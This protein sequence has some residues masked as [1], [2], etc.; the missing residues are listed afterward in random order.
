ME[1]LMRVEGLRK[2]FGRLEVL[3]DVSFTVDRGDV[4]AII[5]PSGAGKSTILRCQIDLE[6]ADG[7]DAGGSDG[8]KK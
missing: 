1:E 8:D 6:K 4:I 7:G 2:R 5:G 3:K